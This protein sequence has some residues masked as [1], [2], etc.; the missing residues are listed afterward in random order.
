M[1]MIGR[2]SNSTSA[3][4]RMREFTNARCDL[5]RVAWRQTGFIHAQTPNVQTA[6]DALEQAP[7]PIK[8]VQPH[9][10]FEGQLMEQLR[11]QI[12]EKQRRD[13]TANWIITEV[14]GVDQQLA[15]ML[16]RMAKQ[17]ITANHP[18]QTGDYR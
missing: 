6:L 1:T 2:G 9:L 14:L 10:L 8:V 3:T 4:A 12:A 13:K 17:A 16:A 15:E 18:S 11:L 7:Q 5:T